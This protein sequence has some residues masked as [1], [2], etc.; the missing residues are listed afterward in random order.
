[1]QCSQ[2]IEIFCLQSSFSNI[3]GTWESASNKTIDS[4]E[5]NSSCFENTAIKCKCPMDTKASIR[6]AVVFKSKDLPLTKICARKLRKY[7]SGTSIVLSS[8]YMTCFASKNHLSII[9][10][11]NTI[12]DKNLESCSSKVDWNK[13][14]IILPVKSS[15]NINVWLKY[16]KEEFDCKLIIVIKEKVNHCG[17]PSKQQCQFEYEEKSEKFRFK[18]CRYLCDYDFV[19]NL[20]VLKKMEKST[21]NDIEICEITTTANDK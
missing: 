15:L 4:F 7:D 8:T 1:M 13:I 18:I 2:Y 10:G 20:T 21:E 14:K 9:N 11:V 16:N 12:I 3:I 17:W 5:E 6:G 19:E